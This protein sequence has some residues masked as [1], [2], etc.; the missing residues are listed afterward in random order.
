MGDVPKIICF[1]INPLNY[2]MIQ[3][4]TLMDNMVKSDHPFQTLQTKAPLPLLLA[5][6]QVPN[7][8]SIQT[9]TASAII[10]SLFMVIYLFSLVMALLLPLLKTGAVSAEPLQP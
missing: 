4:Y 2:N 1:I 8:A 7:S 9:L 10:D 3:L 5:M 6:P